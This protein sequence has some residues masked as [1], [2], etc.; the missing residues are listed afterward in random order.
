MDE[1]GFLIE[2]HERTHVQR[3]GP[4]VKY[5]DGDAWIDIPGSSLVSLNIWGFTPAILGQL[6]DHFGRFLAANRDRLTTAEFYLPEVVGAVVN[7]GQARV[8]VLPTSAKWFGVTYQQD[9][10]RV[11][12]GIWD[13]IRQGV[14]PEKLWG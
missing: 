3:F 4:A 7:A 13:L 9:Q 14:Y 11:R 12:A 1:D 6:G 8:R 2:I 10:A 5:A